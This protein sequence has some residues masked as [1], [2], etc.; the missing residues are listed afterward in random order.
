[1]Q[2]SDILSSG[3]KMN[4]LLAPL[5]IAGGI[6]G[7]FLSFLIYKNQ[8]GKGRTFIITILMFFSTTIILNEVIR[9]VS[10]NNI[11]FSGS[12][13]AFQLLLGPMIYFYVQSLIDSHFKHSH[14]DIFHFIPLILYIIFMITVHIFTNLTQYVRLINQLIWI[15]IIIQLFFYLFTVKKKLVLFNH[16]LKDNFADT[17]NRDLG[18]LEF[19]F[20]SLCT[21]TVF[22]AALIPL[23]VHKIE[24]VSRIHSLIMA[25]FI[26][27]L[28]YKTLIRK[29]VS[30]TAEHQLDSQKTQKVKYAKSKLPDEY[31]AYWT[32]K[33]STYIEN[34]KV[35]L[36]PELTLGMLAER[37][38]LPANHLSQIINT[39]LNT[40]FYD[41]INSYRIEEVKMLFLQKN[42]NSILDIALAA[43]FNSKTTFNTVFKRTTEFTPKEYRNSM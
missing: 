38:G 27:V 15:L 19:I 13:G 28:G 7:I 34:E 18:W 26:L 23:S 20:T 4:Q 21:I 29:P 22:Y 25:A 35:Y 41:L 3:V 30:L 1:M 5:I 11:D 10:G 16:D 17:K 43:G 8:T 31:S 2:I 39:N 9:F 37:I 36:D 6:Q 24:N 14:K 12:S 42:G 32:N 40:T 33:I